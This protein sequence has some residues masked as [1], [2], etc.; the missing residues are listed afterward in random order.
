MPKRIRKARPALAKVNAAAV[1][2]YRAGDHL[3]L[4]Q[5]LGLRPWQLSRL[6]V[7]DDVSRHWESEVHNRA[8][9]YALRKELE[10]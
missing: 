10:A 9:A 3:A 1:S 5:A 6:D 7:T 2:A 4:H 8:W